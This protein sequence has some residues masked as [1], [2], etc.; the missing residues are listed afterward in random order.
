MDATPPNVPQSP[1]VPS[2]PQVAGVPMPRE[3]ILQGLQN[4]YAAQGKRL[5]ESRQRAERMESDIRQYMSEP[6]PK[7]PDL[8]PQPPAPKPLPEKAIAENMPFFVLMAAL[9]GLGTRQPLLNATNAM[10]SAM[11]GWHKGDMEGYQRHLEEWDR[12][13]KD[14]LAKNR[15]MLDR[16]KAIRDDRKTT[17]AEKE[18]LFQL[19]MQADGF[20]EKEGNL[21]I[22]GY[23]SALKDIERQ[24]KMQKDGEDRHRNIESQIEWRK[25]KEEHS[26]EKGGGK[27]PTYFDAEGNQ[28]IPSADNQTFTVYKKGAPP[29]VKPR[30]DVDVSKL[31]KL[32]ST[33]GFSAVNNRFADRVTA[34]ATLAT[35]T[36]GNIAELGMD[37]SSGIFQLHHGDGTLM[38]AVRDDLATAMDPQDV[39]TYQTMATGLERTLAA[40]ETAGMMPNGTLIGQMGKLV[41]NPGDTH[42]TKMGKLAEIRQI[43]EYGTRFIL[44]NPKAP[45]G[46]KKNIEEAVKQIQ[47]EIPYTA[48]DVARFTRLSKTDPTLTLNDVVKEREKAEAA[49]KPRP[50]DAPEDAKLAPDGHWYS[51]DAKTKKHIRWD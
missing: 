14:A 44:D 41:F 42:L 22:K 43:I 8:L 18:Y 39:Q 35:Q 48:R 38:G 4:E 7:M 19:N 6:G 36:A 9:G 23:E 12:Q 13:T 49:A 29:E 31:Q 26:G 28:Y 34:A 24:E 16:Y 15:Q 45:E 11:A 3:V 21:R 2:T 5:Q 51:Y 47:K 37:V 10:A 27:S 25:F 50:K 33:G 1:A 40:I 30:G 20:A 17:L 46:D 32:G